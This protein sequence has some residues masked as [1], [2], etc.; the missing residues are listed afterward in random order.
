MPEGRSVSVLIPRPR[1]LQRF[2]DGGAGWYARTVIPAAGIENA[3]FGERAR[4]R[5]VNA[6]RTLR[7]SLCLS[8]LA[9]ATTVGVVQ[10]V[11]LFGIHRVVPAPALI[12]AVVVVLASLACLWVGTF[13]FVRLVTR[14]RGLVSAGTSGRST[15]SRTLGTDTVVSP[16]SG[17]SRLRCARPM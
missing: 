10:A 4:A 5:A 2:G 16:C 7:G 17:S 15:G 14:G 9:V 8:T 13:A 1:H 3:R 12:A 6:R 11:S